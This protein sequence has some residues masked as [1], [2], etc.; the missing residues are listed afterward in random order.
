[1]DYRDLLLRY[2][3]HVWYEAGNPLIDGPCPDCFTTAECDPTV[4]PL[5]GNPRFEKLVAG[6]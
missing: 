2:M 5:R 6:G 1:M 4:A 3:A